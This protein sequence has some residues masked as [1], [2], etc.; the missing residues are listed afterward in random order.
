MKKLLLLVMLSLS[1]LINAQSIGVGAVVSETY[2]KTQDS[3]TYAPIP[4]I[5]IKYKNFFIKNTEIGLR[6]EAT[7]Y[8]TIGTM[9]NYNFSGVKA[10]DLKAP[11]NGINDRD[12]QYE[13]GAFV[14]FLNEGLSLRAAFYKDISDTSDG[15]YYTIT[16][17]NK[18][19][20]SRTLIFTPHISYSVYDDKFAD[21]YY[22][23]SSEEALRTGLTAQE[24]KAGK[25]LNIGLTTTMVISRNLSLGILANYNKLSDEFKT[26]LIKEDTFFTGGVFIMYMWQ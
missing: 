21:Y 22:G 23:I 12:Q 14:E 1:T 24:S 3:V 11:Y 18:F 2:Y 16:A 26:D 8:I 15:S 20:L 6:L 17:R 9:L 19:H 13:A 25:K 7:D 10:K 5:D 4:L